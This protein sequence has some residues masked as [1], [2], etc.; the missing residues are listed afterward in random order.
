MELVAKIQPPA[1]IL[2]R[3]GLTAA[4]LRSK[5]RSSL[6]ASAFREAKTL[7]ESNANVRERIR[8]KAGM[9][10]EDSLADI[11]CIIK[12]PEM[13]ASLK[14]EA[15]KQLGIFADVGKQKTAGDVGSGFKLT[16]NLGD[17]ATKSVTIDGHTVDPSKQLTAED[18]A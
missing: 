10:L 12:N 3:Y 16:I 2:A 4:D 13:A 18:V 1:E 15:T 7:W 6:W 5:M 11:M 14:L 9:L 8:Y 17:N